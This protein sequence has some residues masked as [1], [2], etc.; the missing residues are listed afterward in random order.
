MEA[1]EYD[2]REI[3]MRLKSGLADVGMTIDELAGKIGV[4]RWTVNEWIVGRRSPKLID[5]AKICDVLG[6]PLDWLA[7]RDDLLAGR[8]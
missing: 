4:S 5:A 3:G 8:A 7:R 1:C 2:A 6:K